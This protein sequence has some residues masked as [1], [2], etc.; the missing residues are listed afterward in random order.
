MEKKFVELSNNKE[1]VVA[2]NNMGKIKEVQEILNEYKILSLKDVGID[3]DVDEDKD[4]FEGNAI[5]KAET[6]AKELGGR[7]CLTDDSG[8]EIDYLDGFPGV[9]TKRWKAGSDRDRNLE[10]IKKLEGVPKEKRKIKFITA[11]AVSDGFNTVC[12][13]GVLDG[14]VSLEPRGVNGFGFDEIFEL[15]DGRTLAELS[16]IEKNEVSARR[17]ALEMVKEEIEKN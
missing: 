7:L 9:F 6:I 17:V 1:I 14:I 13:C 5:K 8:I 3:I 11:I 15:P 4:T 16:P 12:K 2:S 10:I